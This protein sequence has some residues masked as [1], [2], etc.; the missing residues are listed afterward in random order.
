MNELFP[1]TDRAVSALLDDLDESGL[2]DDTL[3]MTTIAT[4]ITQPK[5]SLF[6]GKISKAKS[7]AI[8]YISITLVTYHNGL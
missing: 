8:A 1:P 5:L 6:C 7:S 4:R 2:L 3:F